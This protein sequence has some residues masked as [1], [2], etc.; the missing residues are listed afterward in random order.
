MSRVVHFEIHAQDMDK[1]EK[2]YTDVFG[3]KFTRMGEAM[4]NYRV[5]VTGEGAGPSVGS[6]NGGMTQRRGDLPKPG[7]AVNAYVCIVGVENIDET[8]AK[9]EAA[10]GMLALAKMDV[11]TVGL[12]AY[13]KDPEGN[14]FGILQPSPDMTS[15]K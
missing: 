11:P 6:I 7:D 12:L 4:G 10:G 14:I 1:M 3:W 5:I 9:L 2:F 13:Y 15:A 8:I